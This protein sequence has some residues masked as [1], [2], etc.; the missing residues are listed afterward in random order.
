M[1]KTLYK[2]MKKNKDQIGKAVDDFIPYMKMYKNYMTAHSAATV[3]IRKLREDKNS[4]FCKY[5]AAKELEHSGFTLESY[6]ILP[7]QRLP[8]YELCLREIIKLT[9]DDH[10]V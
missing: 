9:K 1:N 7:I 4:E 3:L 8:R 10:P 6:L 5:L 2:S